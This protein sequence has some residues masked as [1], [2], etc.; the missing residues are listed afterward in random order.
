MNKRYYIF[1]SDSGTGFVELTEAEFHAVVGDETQRRYTDRLYR[2]KITEDDVPNDIRES[3][4]DIVLERVK[5]FGEYVLSDNE[6]L[7]ILAGRTH[8]RRLEAES[9]RSHIETAVQ[10]LPANDALT[11]VTLHPVWAAGMELAAG[12]RVQRNGKL[13]EVNEGKTHT[14]IK[15][16]EPEVATSVFTVVNETNAGTADDPIPYDGNMALTEGLYYTQDGGV[17]KCTRNTVNPVYAP[18]DDLVG[19]YVEMA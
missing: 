3:V 13:Y 6:S 12:M 19:H 2:G 14:A 15:G 1:S 18:L 9:Y 10:S 11:V 17:Y 16:W 4:C 8:M 7:E 5:R